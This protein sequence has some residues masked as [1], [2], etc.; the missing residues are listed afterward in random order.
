MEYL[1]LSNNQL[2]GPVPPSLGNLKE[3]KVF[4]IN[5]N[6]LNG[7][8][9]EDLGKLTNLDTFQVDNNNLEG[10]IPKELDKSL[11]LGIHDLQ[12]SINNGLKAPI[13][14]RFIKD[15]SEALEKCWIHMNTKPGEES[16]DNSTTKLYNGSPQD[17]SKWKGIKIKGYRVTEIGKW[18]GETPKI[19]WAQKM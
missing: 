12:Y 16:N 2:G 5:S 11:K 15:E 3:L 1:S 10:V 6:H 7:E 4:K 19:K 17:H 8:L 9:H 13:R 18:V 14:D